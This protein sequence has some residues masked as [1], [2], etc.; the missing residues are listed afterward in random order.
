MRV[1]LN[2]FLRFMSAD[3]ASKVNQVLQALQEYRESKDFYREFRDPA[4]LAIAAHDTT[5]LEAKV[6]AIER[7]KS[8]HYAQ[9]LAGL[10][11]WI[12]KT[13]YKVIGYPKSESWNAGEIRI[14]VNPEILI[15][16]NGKRYIVKLYMAQDSLS[17]TARKA[18]SW[19][20]K[21]THGSSAAPAILE[22]RKGK[23]SPTPRP[24]R[25][26]AQWIKAEVA[27]FVALWKMNKA[28]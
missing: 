9:C 20:I 7:R 27:A 23:L 4:I 15:D 5:N 22:V 21:H 1:G 11:H 6:A 16:V 24:T 26:I 3:G 14:A 12:S 8:S 2:N 18:L 10:H 13:D 28:A 25:K 17:Q 19:L